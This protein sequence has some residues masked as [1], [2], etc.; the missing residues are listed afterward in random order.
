MTNQDW[1][2]NGMPC[3]IKYLLDLTGSRNTWDATVTLVIDMI[4]N[5]FRRKR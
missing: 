2:S 5:K 4:D 1:D 3:M